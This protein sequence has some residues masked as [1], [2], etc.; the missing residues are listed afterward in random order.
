GARRTAGGDRRVHVRRDRGEVGVLR[1]AARHDHAGRRD[2]R[3]AGRHHAPA[4]ARARRRRTERGAARPGADGTGA[5][6]DGAGLRV[7]R[8]VH[9]L[10]LRELEDPLVPLEDRMSN[11]LHR[12]SASA[13]GALLAL[14][15]IVAVTAAWWALALWPAGSDAPEW[16]LRTREVCFGVRPDGLPDAGGWVLLIG[17]PVGMLVVL[18]AVWGRDLLAGLALLTS[19]TA[20]QIAAGIVAAALVAGISGVVVRVRTAGLEPFETGPAD[21]AARLT[22][23]DDTPPAFALTDQHGQQVTLADFDGRPVIVAFV[24]AHCETV[25]PAIVSDVLES[26]Q[27][28][29]GPR[30]AV[31]FVTLDPWRDTPARL[32]AIARA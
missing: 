21:H 23:L 11:A 9:R 6:H 29:R 20:G 31:L 17:Q 24:Y 1:R 4:G 26:R 15:A 5:G 27:L 32:P 13:W 14:A 25:C 2:G 18:V 7:P 12:S 3:R 10:L 22:R 19:R 28:A 8:R 16:L 30:P